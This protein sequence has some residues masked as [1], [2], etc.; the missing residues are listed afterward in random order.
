MK[1]GTHGFIHGAALAAT[2]LLSASAFA[3]SGM[4]GEPTPVPATGW[5]PA[6]V[7][8]RQGMGHYADAWG[9]PRPVYG[10][11]EGFGEWAARHGGA[12][13]PSTEAA[14][15]GAVRDR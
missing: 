11:G 1:I 8:D 15:E 10:G 6:E 14:G 4:A 9:L 7:I 5:Y 13:A 3:G 2:V 12:G